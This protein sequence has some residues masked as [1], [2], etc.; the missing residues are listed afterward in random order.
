MKKKTIFAALPLLS[1]TLPTY[2][3]EVAHFPMDV[4]MYA[5]EE[6]V[7][8]NTYNLVSK[9]V[10]ENIPG[11]I[12]Q[13]LRL[14]G[15]SSYITAKING[16][17]IKDKMTFS[18]WCAAETYPMM[19]TSEAQNIY[20][21]IAGNLDDTAQ[22]GFGFMLSSQGDMKFKCYM[23]VMG[24][25][26][27]I[28]VAFPEKMKTYEWNHL[29]AVVDGTAKTIKLYLNGEEKTTF[30][31]NNRLD[32]ISVGSAD[33]MIGKPKEDL[34]Q[35]MFLIN[36][37]NGLID[38]IT[39]YDTA[40]TVDEIKSQKPEHEADLSIPESRFAD[41]LLRPRFHGMPGAGWTNETHGLVKYNGK[42]HVFFQ[43]NAN[44]AYMARL[45]WGHITSDNL[46][47]WTE[48]KI[49]IAPGESYDIKGC[50]SG[51]VFT[52]NFLTKG[53]P[54]I[55]YTAVDNGRAT[56]S[57][58]VSSDDGLIEWT[59]DSR[60]PVINGRP[61][62]L[63]DDFRDCYLFANDGKYYMIVGTS[64]DNLGACTLH[65]YDSGS[66]TWSNDGSIFFQA[67]S[68]SVGGRF[69][70]MP[71][72]TPM[73]NGKWLFTATPLETGAGVE[74][75]YWVGTINSDG[76][77]KP[78]P[79]Y[80]SVPGKVELDGFSRDG[81]GLLSPSITQ[82]DGK[83]I[84]LGIVPDKLPSND[85]YNL[86]WAHNYSL[87]REWSLDENDC[88]VQK[89]FEGLKGM[90][91]SAA[92]SNSNFQLSGE[93]N[94]SPVSGRMVEVVGEFEIG[95]SF[96]F[97]FNFFKSGDDQFAQLSYTPSSNTLKLDMSRLPRMTNDNGVFNGVY[98]SQLPES[99]SKGDIIKI[100]AFIDHSII[101]IFINDKWA[102]S[103]RLF[104]TS[105]SANTVEAFSTGA[106]TVKSLDAWV[107]D[108]NLNAAGSVASVGTENEPEITV[109]GSTLH[110]SNVEADSVLS[111]YT[112]S[113]MRMAES[114]LSGN[115]GQV[116][117]NCEKGLYI[118]ELKSK[119]SRL[120]KKIIVR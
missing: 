59:K 12:G 30:Y 25:S 10:P 84:A 114:K 67:A 90:R 31:I 39:V 53:K 34:R 35:D 1:M 86:G 57:H 63:S 115:E 111:L 112:V 61:N 85:N 99:F 117:L 41:N 14:D 73:G 96:D 48:E 60:N 66:G 56:I 42:Y 77:F 92:Y 103:V 51:C 8:G 120:A 27:P 118:A 22:T 28:E 101:D 16:S 119:D 11:A 47:K 36:T 9:N 15:Y 109:N 26:S 62:G 32:A 65:R 69:W 83:T 82:T 49:A 70:E 79:A 107:L 3:G 17:G 58:A 76:T 106:T 21:L 55:W 81:Y 43:K 113:G 80:E 91:S 98:Q 37:F 68:R 105:N 110:Y 2:S 33:F 13:A 75:L 7:T 97:G 4:E 94:L 46:Y 29:V 89:P 93:Q 88:L 24:F 108:E 40:L 78:L 102:A 100:H 87:P 19:I 104:P 38:D 23:S 72:I 44:G 95:N 54:E 64:K 45:H 50:W 74:V 71:N 6:T 116:T 20:S 5:I 18:V 52:D